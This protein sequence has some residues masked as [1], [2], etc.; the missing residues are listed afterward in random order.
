MSEFQTVAQ[1]GDIVEGEGKSFAVDGRMV[2]VFLVEGE[3]FAISDSCP[4]MG[5]S[6]ASGYVEDGAVTCPWHAWRFCVRDGTWLD[7]PKSKL[8][9]DCYRVRVVGNDIQVRGLP[10]AVESSDGQSESSE[11]T[12]EIPPGSE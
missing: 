12:P 3:Y 10:D 2:G 9:T 7:N 5:A 4:H 8:K 11:A 1:V 6:L